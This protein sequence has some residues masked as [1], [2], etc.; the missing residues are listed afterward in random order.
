[1]QTHMPVPASVRFWTVRFLNVELL[2]LMGWSETPPMLLVS[3]LSR[4][5]P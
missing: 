4:T 1:M 5:H 2:G 3:M